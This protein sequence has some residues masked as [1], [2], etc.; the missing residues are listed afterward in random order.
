MCV[1]TGI[2]K[3]DVNHIQSRVTCIVRKKNETQIKRESARASREVD[4]CVKD[5]RGKMRGDRY[6]HGILI[7]SVLSTPDEY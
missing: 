5:E 4:E 6:T 7:S 1:Y 3:I 2:A